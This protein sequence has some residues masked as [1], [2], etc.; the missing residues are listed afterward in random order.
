MQEQG[1]GMP[2]EMGGEQQQ[3]MPDRTS[4]EPT[5][6]AESYNLVAELES[7]QKGKEWLERKAKMVLERWTRDREKSKGYTERC[8]ADL[9]LFLGRGGVMRGAAEGEP[10]PCLPILSKILLRIVARVLGMA[11]TTEPIPVPT[12]D[13][14]NDR[15]ERVGLHISWEKRAKHPDWASGMAASILQWGL[16]GSAIRWISWDP[17]AGKKLIEPLT[18]SE[19]VLPYAYKDHSLNF[20]IVPHF[21]RVR[22]WPRWKIEQYADV[23]YFYGVDDIF[24][25]DGEFRA[26]PIV[27]SE[28]EPAEDD[29]REVVIDLEGIEPGEVSKGE[30][31]YALLEHHC[32]DYLPGKKRANRLAIV[33]EKSTKKVLRLVV[34][35]REDRLDRLRFANEERANQIEHENLTAEY[36]QALETGQMQAAEMGQPFDPAQ[37][38]EAPQPKQAAPAKTEAIFPAKHY[39]FW[40]NPEGT[41]GLGVGVFVSQINEIANNLM[42]ENILAERLANVI[43]GFMSED[44]G[45]EKKEVELKYGKFMSVPVRAGE[46]QGSFMPFQFARPKGN[47]AQII[48]ALDQNCQTVMSSSDYQSG[49][50]GPS[51]E[52]AAA[53]KARVAEGAKAIDAAM[54]MF[55]L[56]LAEEYREY[57]R[58]NAAYMS[59]EEYF[60]VTEPDPQNPGKDTKLR[61]S[62][63]RADYDIDFDMTFT[64]DARMALDP[65]VGQS[66]MQAYQ[67]LMADP[68]GQQNPNLLLKALKKVLKALKASDL[69]ALLPDKVPE[70]PPP[71]PM[72]QV[73]ENAGFMKEEDHPVL[74]DD[75]HA[76]HLR[77]MDALEHDPMG[78]F[79]GLTPTGKQMF[80]RHRQGHRSAAYKLAA[81][82]RDQEGLGPHSPQPGAPPQAGPPPV[83]PPGLPQ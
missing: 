56:P 66:A 46:M 41:L 57:A 6:T 35:E 28:G 27:P 8:A 10:K 12:N 81:T 45:I 83:Q 4:K 72:S 31:D 5:G 26:R 15:V 38:G 77:E 44:L 9:E 7:T 75:D 69:A 70:P 3:E 55:L 79:E 42:G 54:E 78:L 16:Y 47:I 64:S 37:L 49:M 59:D 25:E 82:I 58:I 13:E 11:T 14:D 63:G 17:V 29:L 33:V 18:H 39:R 51:H 43:G 19:F 65:G 74:P 73:D 32:W 50:P 62:V 53:A 36:Q 71:S 60:L 48:E 76:H 21:T 24:R 34:M 1:Q 2:P 68:M 30:G 80:Q 61:K 22:R 20:S 40:E 52:T 67:V 23:G